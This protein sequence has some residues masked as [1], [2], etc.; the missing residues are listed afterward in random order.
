MPDPGSTPQNQPTEAQPPQTRARSAG[1]SPHVFFNDACAEGNPYHFLLRRALESH[2]VRVSGEHPSTLIWRDVRRVEARTGQRVDVV[3]V[4]WLPQPMVAKGLFKTIAKS[5]TFL[6]QIALMRLLGKRIVWTAHDLKNHENTHAWFDRRASGVFA[7]LCHRVIAHC[8]AARQD[9]SAWFGPWI[10][11]RTRVAPHGSYEDFYGPPMDRAEAR[12]RL[13]L[14]IDARVLVFLGNIRPYKGVNEMVER[15]RAIPGDH[16]RLVIAGRAWDEDVNRQVRERI[17]DDPR[18][19]YVPGFVAVDRVPVFM[20]ACDV[21]VFPYRDIL[22]SG[23]VLLAMTFGRACVAVRRAC[24]RE[25]LDDAGSFLY[26]HGDERG[27][28]Q[29]MRAAVAAGQADLDARGRH[30]LEL[31]AKLAWGPIALRTREVY[32]EAISRRGEVGSDRHDGK[33][34]RQ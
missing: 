14:P 3:H 10:V 6:A 34:G 22:T 19:V 21:A 1:G 28:E 29:A 31:A 24:I 20:S 30:N 4:H 9:L 17:G 5:T 18:I 27:L 16:L 32:R 12:R 7:R 8:D 2:G 33:G 23:A 25:T 26:E 13:G 15:F 11:E